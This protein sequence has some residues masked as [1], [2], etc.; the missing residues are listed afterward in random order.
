MGEI[1]DCSKMCA[2]ARGAGSMRADASECRGTQDARANAMMDG[3]FTRGK[4]FVFVFF[5]FVSISYAQECR[6]NGCAQALYVDAQTQQ[7]C[8]DADEAWVCL[9]SAGGVELRCGAGH[10]QQ[11]WCVP[12]GPGGWDGVVRWCNSAGNSGLGDANEPLEA[13]NASEAVAKA[14]RGE[15]VVV[16]GQGGSGFYQ[17]GW[18]SD[19]K[20]A[21]IIAVA[22]SIAIVAL[23]YI[24][25][26]ALNSRELKTWAGME[27][28]QAFGSVLIVAA[29]LGAIAFFDVVSGEIA[30]ST[31]DFAGYGSVC[32]ENLDKPCS[33]HVAQIYLGNLLQ[34]GAQNA[35]TLV[36]NSVQ[37]AKSASFRYGVQ[38]YTVFTLWSGGSHG[39]NAGMSMMVDRYNTLL[40]YYA[41]A[42]ASLHAQRFFSDVII[43]GIGPVFLLVG[44]VLRTFFFARKLGGL[45]LAIAIALMLIYPLTYVFSWLTLTVAVY[46]NNMFAQSDTCPAECKQTAPVVA[47]LA[48]DG[49]RVA[50]PSLDS[51]AAA[52]NLNAV[53]IADGA[54]SGIPGGSDREGRYSFPA[55][56][57]QSVVV[58]EDLSEF[59]VDAQL[60]ACSDCP[61]MCREVPYP[62]Y[63]QACLESSIERACRE[64]DVRCKIVR[65]WSPAGGE[66][67][68]ADK[69]GCDGIRNAQGQ[70]CTIGLPLEG[71]RE[72][73]GEPVYPASAQELAQAD[74]VCGGECLQCPSFCRVR[75]DNGDGTFSL[76]GDSPVCASAACRSCA[77]INGAGR[78]DG[79]VRAD[80]KC[81][82]G[83]SK[84]STA[85]CEQ[86]CTGCPQ[87]CRVR[88]GEGEKA[89]VAGCN[90]PACASCPLGCFADVPVGIDRCAPAPVGNWQASCVQCP[91]ICRYN[92]YTV[93]ADSNNDKDVAGGEYDGVCADYY[94]PNG[95]L[96]CNDANCAQQCKYYGISESAEDVS[97]IC[98]DYGDA[99]VCG[100]CTPACRTKINY[101]NDREQQLHASQKTIFCTQA[102]ACNDASCTAPCTRSLGLP[103]NARVNGNDYVCQPYVGG[104]DASAC[105]KCNYDCRVLENGEVPD[106]CQ[107]QQIGNACMPENCPNECK[108]E[109]GEG[110]VGG[111]DAPPVCMPYL[112]NGPNPDAQRA[113][114]AVPIENRRAPYNDVSACRQCLEECRVLGDNENCGK[115]PQYFDCSLQSCPNECRAEIPPPDGGTCKEVDG[116]ECMGCPLECRLNGVN[117]PNRAQRCAA[118]SSCSIACKKS[119]PVAACDEFVSCQ[120][121][122]LGKPIQVRTDCAEVCNEEELTGISK[123]TP[124][125]FINK[126][127]GAEGEA[128]SKAVGLFML[129][130][131]VLP[132]FN[133]VIIVSFVRVLSPILGGDVEIPGIARLI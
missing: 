104:N 90:I 118:C 78:P 120:Q 9:K 74:D 121:D 123:V 81:V 61:T 19:W 27:L 11:T 29:L 124:A 22:I 89:D 75:I 80:G 3:A 10:P 67:A 95:A 51:F 48:S 85:P 94:Q 42:L 99:G 36:E 105:R 32:T 56:N 33:M 87:Y 114:W 100:T 1:G 31:M 57:L 45:L 73:G 102:Q 64:C 113:P 53:R 68:C 125:S 12:T 62:W 128:Y 41:K 50:I 133:I 117:V 60:D 70:L 23:G 30:S 46:G 39:P 116:R 43:F 6:V 72:V 25:G 96:A 127:G 37:A 49:V 109:I 126:I 82:L 76:R 55:G 106:A 83:I 2:G 86:L 110:G 63:N 119:M 35:K 38:T 92:S 4:I 17:R 98:R 7:C 34:A 26:H 14:Q 18:L 77:G 93:V 131:I 54:I 71:I 115:D 21:S 16:G 5:A 130:A 103:R 101:T 24:F 107:T 111:E 47:Y 129:P 15:G 97:R 8:T 122:C 112:G 59:G 44:I 65:K 40:D 84:A 66:E 69:E 20:A 79:G 88:D 91:N 132:L 28:V 58:C 52:K 13:A 108:V